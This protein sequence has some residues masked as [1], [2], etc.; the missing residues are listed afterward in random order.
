MKTDCLSYFR[1]T[2]TTKIEQNS[3]EMI[4]VLEIKGGIDKL[5]L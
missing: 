5:V 4:T 3:K 1:Q 2:T